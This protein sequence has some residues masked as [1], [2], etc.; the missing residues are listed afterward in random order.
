MSQWLPGEQVRIEYTTVDAT[1]VGSVFLY[2]PNGVARTLKATERLLLDVI[3]YSGV[4][5]SAPELFDDANGNGTIDA[6]ERLLSRGS[7]SAAVHVYADFTGAGGMPCGLGRVPKF[8][9]TGAGLV[10]L[11]GVGRIVNG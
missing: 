7:T 11:N 1:I 5:T 9:G 4:G 10:I 2:T 3:A 8:L 6:G